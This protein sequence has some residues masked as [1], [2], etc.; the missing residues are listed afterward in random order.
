MLEP[1]DKINQSYAELIEKIRMNWDD[2]GVEKLS[3]FHANIGEKVKAPCELLVVGRAVN[4]WWNEFDKKNGPEMKAEFEILNWMDSPE[5]WK[6][7]GAHSPFAQFM[8]KLTQKFIKSHEDT[9]Q[10]NAWTNLYKIAPPDRGNPWSGLMDLQFDECKRILYEE[11]DLLKPKIIVFTTGWKYWAEDFL[12]EMD[13]ER[14]E[15]K[16]YLDAH[17]TYKDSRVFVTQHPQ[18]KKQQV[19]LDEILELTGEIIS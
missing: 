10:L 8:W 9:F 14:V 12:G 15:N 6:K 5:E 16:E 18:G 19:M 4:G 3:S 7:Y 11:I 1:T 2:L 17:G 13:L